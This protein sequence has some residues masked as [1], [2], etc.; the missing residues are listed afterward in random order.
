M[1]RLSIRDLVPGMIIA[2]DIYSYDDKLILAKDSTLNDNI[3]TRLELYS[4]MSVLVSD[5]TSAAKPSSRK[6][7][8]YSRKVQNSVDFILFKNH[9][10]ENID[11]VKSSLDNVVLKDSPID[12]ENL[13]YNTRKLIPPNAST[14]HIFDMLHNLREIDDVTYAHSLNVSLICNAFA[15]WLNFSKEDSD[16]LTLCGLLHDIGKIKVP[17]KVIGKPDKLTDLEFEIVKMHTLEGFKLLQDKDLD[18]R[19]KRAA[20]MHHERCDGS[21]YPSGLLAKNI[22]DYA[23]IVAIADVYDA[24]T[25]SRIYRGPLCPFKVIHIFETEG[26]QKYDP[27]YLLTFLERIVLSYMNNTVLLNDGTY[28]EVIMINKRNL[29]KPVIQTDSGYIDLSG[30]PDLYIEAT[31]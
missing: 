28:G 3:I 31:I 16:V 21:G 4:I 30:K 17:D 5:R 13:L 25:S 22:D 12:V 26:L 2:E 23:K 15:K 24:M 29:A 19:V 20:L 7:S 6:T 11:K 10:Y 27:L 1:K 9:Y 8:S 14:I 18:D